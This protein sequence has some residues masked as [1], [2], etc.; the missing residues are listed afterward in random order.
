MQYLVIILG[1]LTKYLIARMLVG[2][3]LTIVT[4][5]VLNSYVNDLKDM[6]HGF[7]YNLPYSVFFVIDLLNFD[8]YLSTIISCYS[9]AM[10]IKSAKTFIGKA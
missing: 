10:S 4:Y 1:F 2:A 7:F 6:L 5:T 3:G 8:F 9:L